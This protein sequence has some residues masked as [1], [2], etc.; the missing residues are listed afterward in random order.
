M[1]II[2]QGKLNQFRVI[3]TV[4]LACGSVHAFANKLDDQGLSQEYGT[5]PKLTPIVI[6]AVKKDVK[7]SVDEQNILHN[8]LAQKNADNAKKDEIYST[9]L[10]DFEWQKKYRDSDKAGD[11]YTRPYEKYKLYQVSFNPYQRHEITVTTKDS[12]TLY[13]GHEIDPIDMRH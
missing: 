10:S 12:I 6:S 8:Q 5:L 1:M 9:V 7:E 11:K 13:P 2:K 4:L 3:A